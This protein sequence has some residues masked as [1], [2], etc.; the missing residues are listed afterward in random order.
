MAINLNGNNESTYSDDVTISGDLSAAAGTFSGDMTYTS[1]GGIN[2]FYNRGNAAANGG[3]CERI[4][5][6]ANGVLQSELRGGV[7]YQPSS[8]P[9]GATGYQFFTKNDASGADATLTTWIGNDG[10]RIGGTLPGSP[11]IRL[12][13]TGAATFQNET[14]GTNASIGIS[15]NWNGSGARDLIHS[16]GQGD[17]R[18][19]CG[20]SNG[21][22]LAPGATAWASSSDIRLKRNLE[23]IT[24][25]LNKVSQ[26]Q[27]LIGQYITDEPEV[28]R[29][30][31]VAQDVQKVL[32][33]AVH[34][35]EDHLKLAYTEV[36]PLLV[37]ALHD[38]KD[39]IQALEAEVQNLKGEINNG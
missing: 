39:R 3:F 18:V 33:Q 19:R 12:G 24:D 30:F 31:L 16:N 15:P 4:R 2:T 1:A 36:I 34:G 13:A 5:Y 37:S 28:S 21:V 6:N 26:L 32:P 22:D 7:Y 35:D 11:G 8:I 10:I 9:G 27:A 14:G 25:G 20:S 17:L 23:P 29:A 38:A